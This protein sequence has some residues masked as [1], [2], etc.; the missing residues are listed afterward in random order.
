[1]PEVRS[2]ALYVLRL[3]LQVHRS[4]ERQPKSASFCFGPARKE[5]EALVNERNAPGKFGI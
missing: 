5:F 1:M 3:S 2:Q 4:G